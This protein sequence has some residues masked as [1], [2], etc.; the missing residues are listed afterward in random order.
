VTR[1][2][3]AGVVD[4]TVSMLNDAVGQFGLELNTIQSVHLRVQ[5]RF[6]LNAG[7]ADIEG[8]EDVLRSTCSFCSTT[9]AKVAVALYERMGLFIESYHGTNLSACPMCD[10]PFEDPARDLSAHIVLHERE[11]W[12][13]EDLNGFSMVTCSECGEAESV[14][15][16]AEAATFLHHH[17]V[18]H[19][20]E[21][22]L[23]ATA[24]MIEQGDGVSARR[25][26]EESEKGGER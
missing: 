20:T 7:E 12:G 23:A 15:S 18:L 3:P 5:A 25:G 11:A 21:A 17:D 16:A 2:T 6:M 24:V 26:S 13:M 10:A 22:R 1:E 4:A 9:V 8:F 14:A 19:T